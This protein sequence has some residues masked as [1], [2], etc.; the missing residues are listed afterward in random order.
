MNDLIRY[1]AKRL[2]WAIPVLLGASF[3]SFIMIHLAPGDPARFILGE[4]AGAEQIEQLRRQLGLN[5]PL[6]VQYLDFLSDALQGDLGQS[7]RSREQVTTMIMSRLP[8]TVQLA[9]SSLVV[10][11]SIALP[12][13]IVGAL[14]KGTGVDHTS[15][16]VALLGISMPNF[17]LGLLLIFLVAVPTGWFPIFGMTLVT[18][19]P[20]AAVASTVLPALALGTA[21]SAL[22]MRLLRGGILDELGKPYVRTARAFGVRDSEVVY[23]HVLR[24]AVVPTLTIV[25]LQLGYLIGG[26]VII[27][28]VFGIPGIGQMAVNAIFAQDFPVIQGVVL[29]V[30]VVFVVANLIVDIL[31]A[32]LDPRIGYGEG[33][34]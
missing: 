22:V 10:A 1:V 34:A 28:T 2:L 19:D 24:N 21:L 13:G 25:G 32:V 29:L 23:V 26:S 8:Y 5:R 9:V 18:E 20:I 17:W 33:S 4:R 12:T 16:I 11:L 6:H 31:Y 27:E 7:I 14:R 30:A 15:R 3:V